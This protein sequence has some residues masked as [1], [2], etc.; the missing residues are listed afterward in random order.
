MRRSLWLLLALWLLTA[1]MGLFVFVRLYQRIDRLETQNAHLAGQ[2]AAVAARAEIAATTDELERVR[3]EV[4]RQGAALQQVARTVAD[5]RLLALEMRAAAGAADVIDSNVNL[6]QPEAGAD[7]DRTDAGAPDSWF[8]RITG[9]IS[10]YGGQV[11][12]AVAG[13]LRLGPPLP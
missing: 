11:F 4:D 8:Q 10:L 12:R 7:S 1:S 2:L 3:L 9:S 6:E 13:A 5:Q